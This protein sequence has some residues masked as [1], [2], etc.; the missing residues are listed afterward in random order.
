MGSAPRVDISTWNVLGIWQEGDRVSS[1]NQ[2]FGASEAIEK[3]SNKYA[4]VLS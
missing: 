4:F 3:G 2:I 1:A